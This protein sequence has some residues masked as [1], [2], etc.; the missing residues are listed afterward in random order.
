VSGQTYWDFG[1][2]STSNESNPI[3]T[4]IDD[5]IYG[6]TLIVNR[7]GQNYSITQ[8]INAHYVTVATVKINA[9]QQDQ[10]LDVNSTAGKSLRLEQ[11]SKQSAM[12]GAVHAVEKGTSGGYTLLVVAILILGAL[13]FWFLF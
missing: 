12:Y 9:T 3:H 4:Y 7:N 2:G 11:T 1:D 13:S 8:M 6:A 10:M 5:G